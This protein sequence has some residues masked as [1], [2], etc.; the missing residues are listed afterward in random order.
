MNFS[1]IVGDIVSGIVGDMARGLLSSREG[2][3]C[4]ELEVADAQSCEA[5]LA[6]HVIHVNCL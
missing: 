5:S 3:Y 1:D 2:G 6:L 4:L